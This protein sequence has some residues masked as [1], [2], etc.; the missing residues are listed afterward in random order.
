PERTDTDALVNYDHMERLQALAGARR[1]G[2]LTLDASAQAEIER[3]TRAAMPRF[4]PPESAAGSVE[5]IPNVRLSELKSFLRSP[6]EAALRR[7]LRLETA[8]DEAEPADDEP[9]YTLAPRDRRLLQSAL[10]DFVT[11]AT[12]NTVAAALENWPRRFAR[13]YEQW[14][15]RGRLPDGAFAD[16]DRKRLAEILNA[17][18]EGPDGLAPFLEAR[19]DMEYCGPV[20]LGESVIPV[21]ARKRFP[22]LKLVAPSEV[23]LVGSFP[24]AWR[25]AETFELLVLSSTSSRISGA[26]ICKPLLQPFLFYAAL[27][28]GTEAADGLSSSQ[29]LGDRGLVVHVAHK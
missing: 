11:E 8:E 18:I 2:A 26:D 27:K 5:K 29:W 4:A 22:A 19:R 1:N 15:L 10:Q 9:F 21:G 23:R 25:S 12:Q 20:L 13:L 17:C 3:R 28:A 16:V 7:H 6:V 24:L 14:R